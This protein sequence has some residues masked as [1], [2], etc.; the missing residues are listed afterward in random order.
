MGKVQK[1]SNPEFYTPFA[2]TVKNMF[3]WALVY[4][5][6]LGSIYSLLSGHGCGGEK[7]WD[8]ICMK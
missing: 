3:E 5:Q 1:A 4:P 8:V 6:Y 2:R 7:I